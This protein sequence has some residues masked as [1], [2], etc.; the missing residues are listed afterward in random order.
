LAQ[1]DLGFVWV[2]TQ[3]GLNRFD[4][5]QSQL[6]RRDDDS[7]M[8]DNHILS[9]LVDGQDL[10]V[11][12]QAGGLLRHRGASDRFETVAGSSLSGA[13]MIPALAQ[14]SRHLYAAVAGRGL[15]RLDKS[16]GQAEL[17]EDPPSLRF[18]QSLDLRQDVLA[19]GTRD[20]LLWWPTD[21]DAPQAVRF[22]EGQS[23]TVSVVRFAT[24]GQLW[25]GL[26]EDGLRRVQID[27]GRLQISKPPAALSSPQVRSLLIDRRGRVWVGSESGL[28][29]FDP[30]T[31]E[32]VQ[33][34]HDPDSETSLPANRVPALLEDAEGLIW[35]GTWTGGLG[36]YRPDSE[37]VQLYRRFIDVPP[38]LPA[39][40][41]RA[42]LA[43]DDGRLWLGVLEGGGLVH[44]D[45]RQG[46][47]ERFQHDA[48]DPHSL[49]DNRVE[50]LLRRRDGSLW[51]GTGNGGLARLRADG[52]FERF[53]RL[54]DGSGELPSNAV[55]SLYEDDA[56]TLWVGFSDLGL[57]QRCVDCAD[58]APLPLAEDSPVQQVLGRINQVLRSRDGYY[59]IAGMPNGLY[60]YDPL[61]QHLLRYSR[62]PDDPASP[63][64]DSITVL[65]EDRRGRLWAGTQ[66]GGLLQVERDDQGQAIGFSAITRADGLSGDAVGGLLE[67]S[68]GAIWA[69]TISGLTR[70]D[71]VSGA[72]R[73]LDA[74]FGELA[75]GYFIGAAAVGPD[76]VHYF[77]GLR[78]LTALRPA[79]MPPA[80][81]LPAVR[82]TGI[83]LDNTPI[84]AVAV[85]GL[86]I[87][88]VVRATRVLVPPGYGMVGVE[89]AALDYLAPE[90]LRY[91]YRLRGLDDTWLSTP[92]NRRYAAFTRLPA[93]QYQLE[94]RVSRP[95]QEG[96]F[97]EH[98]VDFVVLAPLWRRP[99][100]Q[101]AYVIAAL[102]LG[103]L[104]WHR[105]ERRRER[106]QA[107]QLALRD[108]EERLKLALWGSGDELWDLDLENGRLHRENPLPGLM[109]TQH[110]PD[111]IEAYLEQVHAEEREAIRTAFLEHVRGQRD[112]YEFTYRGLATD[113]SWRWLL[114]RGRSVRRDAQ[115][116]ALRVA[117]TVRDVS[118]SK[119]NEDAL[120]RFADEL[121][122][123]VE[124][125]TAD[126][127][128]AIAQLKRT[129]E[130]LTLTQ[131]QLV[132]SEKMASLGQ[133]VA[134]VAHE[135]NTPIGIGVTAASHLQHEAA[136]LQQALRD[137]RLGKVAL[138]HFVETATSSAHLVLANL[139]RASDLVRSFKQVAVDQSSE[140][141]RSFLLGEYLDEI[142]L[143]LRPRLKRSRHQVEVECDPR[144][145]VSTY[146]GALYQI[147][148][149]LVINSLVHGFNGIDIGHIH[150]RAQVDGEG[151]LLQYR[152]DG[153]G[154]DDGTRQRI[155]D[156][157]F[158][159]R[160][161]EGGSGLGM[162]LVFN[163]VTQLLKG[164]I[165][166]TSAPG[167]GVRFEV[168]L[169]GV[170][171][172]P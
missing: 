55:V 79:L 108:S 38:S 162:H 34:R 41:V 49:P 168:R 86:P 31:G 8:T 50:A 90:A 10:W 88:P 73:N 106:D 111:S 71:P 100:A 151:V 22:S 136:Q 82:L 36:I 18:I 95:G 96:Q 98:A 80:R 166:C 54:A 101:L 150:I 42:L 129:V 7:G 26:S 134:G 167:Q 43:E 105:F 64:H 17:L 24:D 165:E 30:L 112:H 47:L 65:V 171:E 141:K 102:L 20:E 6:F 14:D 56:Q 85:P 52:R 70:V 147:I 127:R 48:D 157:F 156:P 142:L 78:G 69:A 140:Q 170:V 158:T 53:R 94:L 2:G 160:R 123:R 146:P 139:A 117:G 133:L 84:A 25:V 15:L 92:A 89:F 74:S 77:G 172:M 12:T 29:R 5:L 83:A 44:F 153:V 45:P 9:L 161:T 91:E 87:Q 75:R 4:G 3:D 128:L 132:E 37:A 16:S 13:T 130:E 107:A 138:E 114:A 152:D 23:P 27:G 19:I 51:I 155:F 121:E 39:N 58:F 143:S 33:A 120:K 131:R 116:H 63:S 66:G 46:V 126:H 118:E 119:A 115:G 21:A 104:F 148:V 159:T 154:M 62:N 103:Y 67:A 93:G 81:G 76:G 35:A 124:A 113:G 40:P 164:S 169:P 122:S 97:A 11:G 72:L 28:T 60:R 145:S 99:L 163:L 1:D 68:D 144:L 57:V 125:R 135:I 137:G 59:W 110:P 32:S 61:R 149:N 109:V